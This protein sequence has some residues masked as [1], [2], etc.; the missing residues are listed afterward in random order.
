[1]VPIVIIATA[2]VAIPVVGITIAVVSHAGRCSKHFEV[3]TRRFTIGPGR[4][5]ALAHQLRVM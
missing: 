5:V 2:G 3:D 1:M 4:L